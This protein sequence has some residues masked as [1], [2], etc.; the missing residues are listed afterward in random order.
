[1]CTI[2][3]S[4]CGDGTCHVKD[5]IQTA[6][7]SSQQQQHPQPCVWGPSRTT[8]PRPLHPPFFSPF[9]KLR[10]EYDKLE[11]ALRKLGVD[12][13]AVVAGSNASTA[14]AAVGR[15]RD[16]EDDV[17]G[18]DEEDD[19]DV[20][21]PVAGGGVMIV[22]DH[23]RS[24]SGR[25]DAAAVVQSLQNRTARLRRHLDILEEVSA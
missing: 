18:D 19:V 1:M 21:N 7:S 3:V 14:A 24:S 20:L 25:Q 12:P 2:C 11:G 23:S 9:R 6:S 5:L 13:E 10:D 16:D 8:S 4:S 22:T 17:D 15:G